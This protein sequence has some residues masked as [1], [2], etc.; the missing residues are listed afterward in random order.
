MNDK[1]IILS[2]S[3][4]K[5]ILNRILIM[6]TYLKEPL[7]IN[8]FSNCGDVVVMLNILHNLG[9]S[10]SIETNR[11]TIIPPKTLKD[12][13]KL[14]IVD[15]GTVYR[16][17]LARLAGWQ[18]L[19][20]EVTISPQLSARPIN[21]LI[22]LL[23]ENGAE[24]SFDEVIQISGKKINSI[25]GELC[26]KI[27]SQFISA[28]MLLAPVLKNGVELRFITKPVSY[29]YLE[30]TKEVLLMFGIVVDLTENSLTIAGDQ[31]IISPSTITV[32]PDY[33]SACY[34][35]ALGALSKIPLGIKILVENSKQA[36][37]Y[38]WK[39]LHKMGAEVIQTANQ[40]LIKKKNLSGI[41]IDMRNMPDQ[42][43]TLAV[44][45]LFAKGATTIRGIDH[46]K[47]KESNRIDALVKELSK[48]GVI[49][50]YKDSILTINP[51]TTK[52]PK[53]ILLHCYDDHR[54]VMVFSLLTLIYPFIGIDDGAAVTKSFPDFFKHWEELSENLDIKNSLKDITKYE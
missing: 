12:K 34:F 30:L 51:I 4:S 47:Y 6:A 18:G 17:L 25:S 5:S 42:V 44:L 54:L 21:P 20:S 8:N 23:K 1:E 46:L 37:F 16:F 41:D 29:S 52:I 38:F 27:S 32:E 9:F 40:I 50:E 19:E 7:T 24:L 48:L 33:S 39:I 45:A 43:P 53:G 22:Q 11:C 13:V 15:A 31:K 35:W 28:I 14:H 26:G 36:D 10:S 49:I 3:G 2:I